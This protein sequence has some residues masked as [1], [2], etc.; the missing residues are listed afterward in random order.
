M[1]THAQHIAEVEQTFEFAA[2]EIHAKSALATTRAA[3]TACQQER[4][5]LEARVEVLQA[6]NAAL[7]AH[8]V[9]IA[10]GHIQPSHIQLYA[11]AVVMEVARP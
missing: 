8:L 7:R 4:G 1:S 6:E 10:D 3:L 9:R 11:H 5:Q 2:G